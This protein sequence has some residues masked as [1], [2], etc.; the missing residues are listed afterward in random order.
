MLAQLLAHPGCKVATT[1]VPTALNF[2]RLWRG[3]DAMTVWRHELPLWLKRLNEPDFPEQFR[4]DAMEKAIIEQ[5]KKID[6][7]QT[8]IDEQ[9]TQIDKLATTIRFFH[10]HPLRYVS[11]KLKAKLK[12]RIKARLK[13]RD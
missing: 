12:S 2:Q 6:E 1:M 4:V 7:Q 10:R 5:Q 8:Q 13:P 11:G 9:Q 3:Q